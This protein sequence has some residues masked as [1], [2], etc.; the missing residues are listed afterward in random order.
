VYGPGTPGTLFGCLHLPA[1]PAGP[2]LRSVPCCQVPTLQELHGVVPCM[3]APTKI[4]AGLGLSL[5]MDILEAP[6]ESRGAHSAV[7]RELGP[8][9][10][11]VQRRASLFTDVSSCAALCTL[12]TIVGFQAP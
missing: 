3:V 11:D 5:G 4:I 12:L 6:G 9:E 1:C 10:T 8:S 2:D 7:H